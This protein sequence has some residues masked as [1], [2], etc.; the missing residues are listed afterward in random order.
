MLIFEKRG[1][2]EYPGKTCWSRLENQQTQPIKEGK[3]RDPGDEVELTYG[4]ESRNRSLATLVAQ[5]QPCK[6]P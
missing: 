3:K 2:P 6:L 4:I 5:H 1:K